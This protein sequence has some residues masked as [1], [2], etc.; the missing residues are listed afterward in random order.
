MSMAWLLAQSRFCPAFGGT[1]QRSLAFLAAAE[2]A[3]RSLPRRSNSIAVPRLPSFRRPRDSQKCSSV[4][5]L[6]AP[7]ARTHPMLICFIILKIQACL[8]L[9]LT[10]GLANFEQDIKATSGQGSPAIMRSV[11][12]RGSRCERAF[13]RW[14]KASVPVRKLP[15]Q[16]PLPRT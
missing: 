16:D 13:S 11:R 14:E 6:K 10:G 3:P 8:S 2:L 9:S 15:R 4:L 5:C 1:R 7:F 12:E